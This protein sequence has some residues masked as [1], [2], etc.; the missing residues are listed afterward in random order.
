MLLTNT[1][2]SKPCKA[3]A[4]NSL[5]N[6]ELSKIQLHRIGQSGRFLDR[7]LWPLLK[8]GL[9]LTENVL[10][11]LAKSVFLAL[12]GLT[13]AALATD[14]ASLKKMFG[15]DTT[16]LIISN[17]EMHDII[18]IVKS[19]QQ[20]GLLIKGVRKTIENEAKK[21][22]GWFPGMLLGTLGDSLLGNLLTGKSTNRAGEGTVRAGQDFWCRL[23]L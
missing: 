23:I 4:N 15:S 8:T 2:I 18:K 20:W 16:T 10:R 14:A 17:K 22:K 13:A 11:P 12:L 1:Q 7:R 21:Q 3:F 9:P 6:I 19:L 5:A